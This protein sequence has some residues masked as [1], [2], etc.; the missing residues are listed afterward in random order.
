MEI[1][2]SSWWK[3]Q[4]ELDLIDL[5]SGFY[6]LRMENVGA[7][8]LALKIGPWAIAGHYLKVQRWKPGLTHR[9]LKSPLLQLKSE[10]HLLIAGYFTPKFRQ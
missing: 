4:G 7:A 1:L 3:P 8:E 2:I 5:G 10:S 9:K 6:F